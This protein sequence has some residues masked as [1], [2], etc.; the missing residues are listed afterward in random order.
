MLNITHY[1][2]EKHERV[3]LDFIN[4]I[5]P[6]YDHILL[7]K[8]FIDWQFNKNPFSLEDRYTLYLVLHKN[9]IIACLG[10]IPFFTAAGQTEKLGCYPVNLLTDS[11]Y[12]NYG[13]GAL[14]MRKVQQEFSVMINSGSSLD[15]KI[16]SEKIGMEDN[17]YLLRYIYLLNADACKTF[18]KGALRELDTKNSETQTNSEHY[19]MVSTL[20]KTL[21]L[22]QNENNHFVSVYKSNDFLEWRYASHPFLKYQYFVNRVTKDFLI[23]RL[24]TLPIK[25]HRICRVIDFIGSYENIANT[26]TALIPFLEK[27]KIIFVDFL[28]SIQIPKKD[29]SD[30]PFI[31]AN[32]T[33]TI[34]VAYLFNPID[35][36]K[37]GVR[38]LTWADEKMKLSSSKFLVVLGDSDQDRPNIWTE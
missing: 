31:C 33:N 16:L 37:R 2:P 24:E 19:Q 28:T 26:L 6:D 13:F 7:S 3:F 23:F 4:R 32:E 25:N 38:L 8:V 14:L 27:E 15:G 12:K 34:D 18:I 17:G 20:P 29:K 10:Y 11:K 21:P 30:F 9:E 22:N 36:K 5:Y 35:F 1:D